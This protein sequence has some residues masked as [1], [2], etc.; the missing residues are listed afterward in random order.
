M[1]DRITISTSPGRNGGAFLGGIGHFFLVFVA[2]GRGM[3]GHAFRVIGPHA[4]AWTPLMVM[5]VILSMGKVSGA[6][7]DPAYSIAFALRR[8]SRGGGPGYIV[9]QLAGAASPA[10]L[11]RSVM[12]VAAMYGSN[13]PAH[14][15]LNGAGLRWNCVTIGLVS[16]IFGTA[17]G[18][19][20]RHDRR[21]RRRW[22]H[23]PGR[24]SGSRSRGRR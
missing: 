16:M 14:G 22:L 10:L 23:S 6:H 15:Y 19:R 1:V 7:L 20:H 12:D 3:I 8:D 13:Y 9:M 11:L 24:M 5:A 17:S 18:A 4:S 21:L 2:A